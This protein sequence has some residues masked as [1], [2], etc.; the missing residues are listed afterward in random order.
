MVWIKHFDIETTRGNPATR[1]KLETR[2]LVKTATDVYGIAYRW[3]A[4]QT[5]A[6][7][8]AEEGLT[9]TI[10]GS[11]PAQVWRYPSRSEC[12]A[13]HTAAGGFAL[14]FNT[15]QLNRDK[16]FNAVVQNQVEALSGAGYFAALV[17]SARGLP[18][19]TSPSDTTQSLEARVRGYLAANC[20][21][22][23]Q[24]GGAAQGFWDARA[25][26][27]TDAANVI[28]GTLVNTAG[29]AANRFAVPGDIN[30][31]MV[32]K[33]IRGDGVTRMPPLGTNERDLAAEQLL[34]DW[35]TQALPTR[36]SFTQW[37][38]AQFG[39][40]SAPQAGPTLDPDFDG[41]T[42]ALEYL[43][44]TP[45]GS[46]GLP[47]LPAVQAPAGGGIEISFIHPANRSCLVETSADLV[48]WSLWNV[49]GNSPQFPAVASPRTISGPADGPA[50]AYRLRL[51]EL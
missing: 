43:Q 32:L 2:F 42:N 18:K 38:T 25:S 27:P 23:H 28:N 36:Q 51:G 7:L 16:L 6:D 22:C 34:A 31:S 21:Q 4:D 40:P 45:P 24:P 10:A 35:I 50:R 15:R 20:S 46:A 5:N 48:N 47:V 3:R 39:S 14:S 11:N 29:D 17:Q 30:H 49:P 8:V 33:R 12:R 9:E 44:A 37:Q 41:Q 1:R 19:L 13:C 26:V